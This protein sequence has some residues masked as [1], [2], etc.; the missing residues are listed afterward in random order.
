MSIFLLFFF[1]TCSWIGYE[2]KRQCQTAT[3]QY[4]GE[5]VES[6]IK[7]LN[8][9]HQGF[10]AR[11]D[12][13]WALGQLGDERALSTLENYYTGDIPDREPLNEVISQYELKKAVNLTS[14]GINIGAF[15]WR[16]LLN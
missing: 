5:C 3:N 13:I 14:G 2:V 1:I 16:G 4:S 8:D 7:L 6:L 15:I 12:A 9:D 10:R 11:N